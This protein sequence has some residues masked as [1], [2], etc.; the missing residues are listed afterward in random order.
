MSYCY[1]SS[2]MNTCQEIQTNGDPV[3]FCWYV[4]YLQGHWVECLCSKA[5][6]DLTTVS[7]IGIVIVHFVHVLRIK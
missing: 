1:A 2:L 7:E 5:T 3:R 4:S 6:N